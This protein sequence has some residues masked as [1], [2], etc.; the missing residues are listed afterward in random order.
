MF[1]ITI[2]H[3]R[4]KKFNGVFKIE[5]LESPPTVILVEY[6]D[7]NGNLVTEKDVVGSLAA[8]RRGGLAVKRKRKK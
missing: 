6:I 8:M 4:F 5:I 1:I 3:I 2:Y 7:E